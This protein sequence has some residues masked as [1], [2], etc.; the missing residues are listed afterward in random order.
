MRARLAAPALQQ[1]ELTDG[2]PWATSHRK[3]A[4]LHAGL[5]KPNSTGAEAGRA[6]VGE[7]AGLPLH[8]QLARALTPGYAVAASAAESNTRGA[9]RV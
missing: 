8:A 5:P 4:V 3:H 2:L 6:C 7:A 9:R 1:P